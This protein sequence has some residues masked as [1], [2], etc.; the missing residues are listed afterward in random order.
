MSRLTLTL[1]LLIGLSSA[2]ARADDSWMPNLDP[3]LDELFIEE[4]D[5]PSLDDAFLFPK[6][7]H[8]SELFQINDILPAKDASIADVGE[9]ALPQN[10]TT[11]APATAASPVAKA[12]EAEEK[13]GILINFNNVNVVEFIRF[14]SRVTNKNFIFDD[15]DLRF[16]VTMVSEEPTSI[17]NIMTGLMQTLRVHDLMLM[18]QGNNLIIH[19]NKMVNQISSVIADGL[20][21][22]GKNDRA[23]IV[24]QVF[25]LN[26]L[27]VDK[28]ADLIRPLVSQGALVEVLA[29][30]SHIVVTDIKTNVDKI[31]QL[32][33]SLDAP[34]SGLTIG[35]YVVV[36]ALLDSLINL[37]TQ[38]MQPIAESKPLVFVAHSPSNSIFVVST[39]F[40]VDRTLAVLRNLDINVGETRIFSPDSLKFTGTSQTKQTK[41]E[42]AGAA[43][44]PGEPG[45]VPGPGEPGY[46]PPGATG[47]AEGQ[48]PELQA[49]RYRALEALLR[50]ETP[51]GSTLGPGTLGSASPW[52]SNLPAGHIERTKFYIHKLRYRKGDQIGEALS[53]IGISLQESGSSNLDLIASIQSLQWLQASNSLVF[54][55]TVASITKVKE[56]IEEIDTPLRQV[57]LEML[58]LDTSIDES[59][60]FGVNWGARFNNGNTAGAEAFLTENNN[61][62]TTLD[63]AISGTI[64]DPS[65]LARNLGYHLGIVGRNVTHC[66]IEFSSIGALV[67]AL[68]DKNKDD[69]VLNPKILVEDNATAEIFVGINAPFKTQS[70]ANDQGSTITSNFEFRDIGTRLKVTPLISNDDVVTL[71]IEEE[72]SSVA[73]TAGLAGALFQADAGPTTKKS[74]S[75]TKVHVPNRFFLVMS[76]MIQDEHV[77]RRQQVPCLGGVPVLG[78]LFSDKRHRDQKRNLMIFIRP[79]IVDTEAEMDEVTVN[80]QKNWNEKYRTKKMWKY[81]VEEALDLL[82][83]KEPEVSLHDSEIRNP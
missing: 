21:G 10:A 3:H 31:G 83:L 65:L 53:K 27:D 50:G 51:P 38:I 47:A 77:R 57:F 52:S 23:D 48:S 41:P 12:S 19:K 73:D 15:Q 5:D 61:L 9:P 54:T 7:E 69:I 62:S 24:T 68:H 42:E 71:E 78:G 35:Q 79:V 66:G 55:G 64:L 16:N 59:L 82:N 34:T 44:R 70:I 6:E 49:E 60:N 17:E 14:I 11:A 56:L 81:E 32:L 39:P 33:K 22:L 20:P 2:Q 26:T 13:N 29:E 74:N 40:I 45:N 4:G 36:N 28:S 1:I 75:T 8:H 46:I 72:V 30:T 67:N 76:G 37:A 25:R 63:N 43:P 58:L 80:E 18:E